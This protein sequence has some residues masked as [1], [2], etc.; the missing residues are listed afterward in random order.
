MN[1]L[2]IFITFPDLA[3]AER[4]ARLL[5]EQRLAACVNIFP[6]IRSVYKWD[7]QVQTET[8]VLAFIKSSEEL[9]DPLVA[10]VRAH[11][12][13]QLPAITAFKADY[14]PEEVR[15]WLRQS[16]LSEASSRD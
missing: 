1:F 14:L 3:S 12:P 16:L 15:H 4:M 7:N 9:L 2:E 11:H 5:V 8:E 13:Y 10:A 6:G